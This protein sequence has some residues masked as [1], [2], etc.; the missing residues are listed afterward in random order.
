MSINTVDM[1]ALKTRHKAMWMSGDYAK[2][3]TYLFEGAMDFLHLCHIPAGAKVLDVGCGAGQTAIPLARKGIHVTGI[4]IASN[5]IAEARKRAIAEN[6]PIQFDEGDA[7]QLPYEDA[8]FDIVF[9]LIGAM[10]APQPQKVAAEFARVCRPN[11]RIIMGNWTPSGFV[12]Q[13]FKT[14]SAH[15]P[16]PTGIP[17]PTLWGDEETVAGRLSPYVTDLHMTR[18]FYHFKYPFSVAEVVEFFREFYGPT[19]RAFSTLDAHK[20]AALRADLEQLWSQHN[21]AKDGTVLLKA[22]YLEVQAIL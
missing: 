15:V 8:S 12:G 18:R 6:L 3:A 7:E 11:G 5:L 9:S 16:P 21:L 22:E 4:D 2:F 10:F 14:M 19:N 17:S 13:M 20:Q 1:D